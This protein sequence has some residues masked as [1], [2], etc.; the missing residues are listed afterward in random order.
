MGDVFKHKRKVQLVI[1][2]QFQTVFGVLLVLNNPGNVADRLG[3]RVE[4]NLH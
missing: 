2:L 4:V 1:E 3:G